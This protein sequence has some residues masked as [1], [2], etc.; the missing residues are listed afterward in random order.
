MNRSRWTKTAAAI[1]SVALLTAGAV[2]GTLA[3]LSAKTGE[4]V[5]TFTYGDVDLKL[6]ES[7]LL[8]DG[9]L[10]PATR[11][12]ENTYKMIPGA[13]LPK[14]PTVT[15]LAG[16]EKIYLF[17]KLQK[18]E[19]FTVD[20]TEY[21]FDDYLSFSVD[22]EKW[23]AIDDGDNSD[24]T[25]VY[26]RIAESADTEQTFGVLKDNTV[27]VN[28]TVTKEMLNALDKNGQAAADETVYPKLTVTA[29]AMQYAGFEPKDPAS[30][31]KLENPTAEELTASAKTAWDAMAAQLN[32]PATPNP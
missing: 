4:V 10:D 13:V 11:V 12:T 27:T 1:L 26:Y 25:T 14:D 23:T 30:G 6:D 17:V 15:V 29:Y 2:G 9:S 8:P 19:N 16:S 28:S 18:S 22:S 31:E 3:W 20:G 32:P 7:K 21:K 24:L 5:N